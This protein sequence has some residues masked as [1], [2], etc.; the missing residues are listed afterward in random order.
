M[1]RI[2]DTLDAHSM[3]YWK[4]LVKLK[5]CFYTHREVG[6]SALIQCLMDGT[7]YRDRT[8]LSRT[9]IDESQHSKKWKSQFDAFPKKDLKLGPSVNF[10]LSKWIGHSKNLADE[11]GHQVFTN[12]TIKT[13][14]NQ[15]EKV[16]HAKDPN[17]INMYIEIPAGKSS[18][19][20]LSKWQS[21]HP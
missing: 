20:G 19:H 9:Q 14:E 8:K 15:L 10:L 4:V 21:K 12:T 5:A 1:H 6:L 7:F 18:S 11:T 2:V 17:G 16:E 13:V 3:V